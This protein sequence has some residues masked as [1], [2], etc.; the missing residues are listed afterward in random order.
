MLG[1]NLKGVFFGCQAAARVT[2]AQGSGSVVNMSS[3]AIDSPR[4]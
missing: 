1:V 2:T 3:G 4:S